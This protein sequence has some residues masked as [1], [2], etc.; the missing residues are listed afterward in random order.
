MKGFKT[1]AHFWYNV[2]LSAERPVNCV[3]HDIMKHTRN[4]FHLMLRKCKR[5][6]ETIRK[7]KILDACLNGNGDL[8]YEIKKMRNVKTKFASSMDGRT[9]DIL[10]NFADIYS[11]LY[12]EVDDREEIAMINEEIADGVSEDGLSEANKVTPKLV[13]EAMKKLKC[14]KGDAHFNFTSEWS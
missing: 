5:A 2:W 1:D 12:N 8:F 6:T 13:K 9:E 14:D 3:L 4:I 10:S 7:N 11:K